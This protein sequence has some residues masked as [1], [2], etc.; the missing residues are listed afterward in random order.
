MR[1]SRPPGSIQEQAEV[2]GS[3]PPTVPKL[4]APAAE[5]AGSHR[6][7]RR[8]RRQHWG[9]ARARR[10]AQPARSARHLPLLLGT[11]SDRRRHRD[12]RLRGGTGLS[13]ARIRWQGPR[14][15]PGEAGPILPTAQDSPLT[16]PPTA[17]PKPPR[18]RPKLAAGVRTP[19]P[20]REAPDLC[21]RSAD[22]ARRRPSHLPKFQ[23]SE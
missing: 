18:L 4:Q 1:A 2:T 12:R 19:N 15:R 5:P 11:S 10:N 8:G 21:R 20:G 16:A 6:P 17:P 9:G 23:S 13:P 3:P 7:C 14:S 22:L